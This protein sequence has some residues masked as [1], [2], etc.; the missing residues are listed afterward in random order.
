MA[1]RTRSIFAARNSNKLLET[2]AN[3][4]MASAER[5]SKRREKDR[6][7]AERANARAKS[8]AEK[9]KA[10]A[11]EQVEKREKRESDRR[12]RESLKAAAREDQV[13]ERL[14]LE[15]ENV[16]IN[17]LSHWFLTDLVNRI[18]STNLSLNQIG[19]SL[20]RP[21]VEELKSEAIEQ[22][23][24]VSLG[25][26]VSKRTS[27]KALISDYKD[28]SDLESVF[29]DARY[30]AL[31]EEFGREVFRKRYF[32]LSYLEFA[33]FRTF[34]TNVSH[35]EE[36]IER[37]GNERPEVDGKA[38]RDSLSP[39]VPFEYYEKT[40]SLMSELEWAENYYPE[41]GAKHFYK[42]IPQ[43]F[44]EFR[45][46]ANTRNLGDDQ[47][48]FWELE[49]Y[50]HRRCVLANVRLNLLSDDSE[51]L[52]DL[53]DSKDGVL[54]EESEAQYESAWRN[55]RAF[56]LD[57]KEKLFDRKELRLRSSQFRSLLGEKYEETSFAIGS[58]DVTYYEEMLLPTN[59]QL[60]ALNLD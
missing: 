42:F 21:R 16:G 33:P 32:C 24:R 36:L 40:P 4:L 38:G 41:W 56:I 55:R 43:D 17:A 48:E 54:D 10:K 29:T 37:T 6:L 13:K 35:S 22:M 1:R 52:L 60:T 8:T 3:N 39:E 58:S 59:E 11:L 28:S 14:I 50:Y 31:Y 53:I 49:A 18:Q 26:K 57:L 34:Y 44:I 20:V 7:R 23:L 2:V 5:S 9:Q 51:S 46:I 30:Q 45:D 27:L 19:S 15:L 47:Q 25:S 12:R